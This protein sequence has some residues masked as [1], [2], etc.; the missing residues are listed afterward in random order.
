MLKPLQIASTASS[1]PYL[2]PPQKKILSISQAV[3]RSSRGRMQGGNH[4]RTVSP[5]QY[6]LRARKH[7][8]PNE[9]WKVTSW[10][11]YTLTSHLLALSPGIQNK[12]TPTTLSDPVHFNTSHYISF[13]FISLLSWLPPHP[14]YINKL[15]PAF[16]DGLSTGIHFQSSSQCV[17]PCPAQDRKPRTHSVYSPQ[18]VGVS[19]QPEE[20]RKHF[21]ND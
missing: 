20:F 16:P 6:W 3:W 2:H 11:P 18:M 7:H 17:C 21:R 19:G 1:S 14:L 12:V 8:F 15:K 4:L 9:M 13:L 5:W 10:S